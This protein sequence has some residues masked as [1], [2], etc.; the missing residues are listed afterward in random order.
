M[1]EKTKQVIAFFLK[2]IFI[3]T[4]AG[5]VALTYVLSSFGYEFCAVKLSTFLSNDIS[6]KFTSELFTYERFENFRLF[7][8]IIAV[9]A[10]LFVVRLW[11][12][13][14][15]FVDYVF[16]FFGVLT[17]KIK[18]FGTDWK[19]LKS[20]ERNIFIIFLILLLGVRI[21]YLLTFPLMEDE[22]FSYNHFV[23]KGFLV[24][25]SYYPGPN[26]HI[27]YNQLAWGVNL[28]FGN[29]FWSMK[30][31]TFIAGLIIPVF[32][33]MFLIRHFNYTISMMAVVLF[34]FSLNVTV[35]SVIGR[36]YMVQMLLML[37]ML[38]AL[39]KIIQERDIKFYNGVFVM[40][41]TLGFL[42]AP[43]FLYPFVSLVVFSFNF[44][45]LKRGI[46]VK[47][48]VI[49]TFWVFVLVI[50]AYLPV[51][52][53]N[54]IGA[55]TSNDWVKSTMSLGEFFTN[56][57][58]YFAEVSNWLWDVPRGGI[59]ISLVVFGFSIY[60]LMN[61]IKTSKWFWFYLIV[62]VG[63]MP[64]L[65]LIFQKVQPAVR[66]WTYFS[67]FQFLFLSIAF[68]GLSKLLF[69][70]NRLRNV[71]AAVLTAGAVAWFT[72]RVTEDRNQA[73]S[74]YTELEKVT[75]YC[76]E[77]NPGTIWTDNSTALEILPVNGIPTRPIVASEIHKYIKDRY[78][79]TTQE[80]PESEGS[81][82][83]EFGAYKLYGTMLK[84]GTN[85]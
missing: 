10:V 23:S 60:A 9:L 34:S 58:A 48:I 42:T 19:S 49:D 15:K 75:N 21:Y 66:I 69:H 39:I 16:H 31:P 72:F 70:N 7:I 22:A 28:V 61:R 11:N 2:V 67:F 29:A 37:L 44:G 78:I 82:I 56:L 4:L 51:F 8:W 53:M 71:V 80:L 74:I 83:K 65:I 38:M 68:Y 52:V 3:I 35:Y 27:F 41:A 63:L 59:Y 24:S 5:L 57:P 47:W 54:G 43:T 84:A 13:I 20:S 85:Y 62:S 40:T 73:S 1:Q 26:N 81:L 18:S 45:F 30:L 25:T 46:N 33:F 32:M 64:I 55:V 50:A 76:S 17:Q 77:H 36:G 12:F 79:L 6:P 14:P